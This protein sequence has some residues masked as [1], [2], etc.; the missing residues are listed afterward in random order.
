VYNLTNFI[1]KRRK[2]FFMVTS[3]SILILLLISPV[4]ASV[5]S[6]DFSPQE[7][8]CGDIISI[9]GSASPEEN[10]D[11]FVTFE[12]NVPVSSG[13]FEYILEDVKIPGGLNNRF[14]VEARGA[15]NLNVRVKMII[16]VTKH[17][18]ASG[19][20]ATVSQ[21]NVPPGTYIIKIDGD[22][23]EGTSNVDLRITAFQ[24]MKADSKGDFSYSYNTKAV[25]SGDFEIQV[26][27]ITKKE[28]I[29]PVG[30]SDLT[31]H[32]SSVSLS[33]T[34]TGSSSSKE[35]KSALSPNSD[36]TSDS[37]SSS[38]SS[39]KT[40]SSSSKENES[41]LLTENMTFREPAASATLEEKNDTKILTPDKDLEEKKIQ[42][43][44]SEKSIQKSELFTS[45]MDKFYLLIGVVVAILVLILYSRRK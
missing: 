38:L 36:S 5:Y 28:T 45:F 33:S 42:A 32:S 8:V 22:A 20:A 25:P 30:N 24:G 43:H 9:K 4:S 40:G 11:V 21:S 44:P 35:N 26:G 23:A 3:L 16:W 14:T 12:K 17:S 15:K 1:N 13:K 37:S 2:L 31:S 39:A 29:Q 41:A 10:V 18:E 7:P 19:N 27:D 6:W 34:K